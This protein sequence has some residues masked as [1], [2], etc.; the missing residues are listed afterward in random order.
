M[1][2]FY[3]LAAFFFIMT[4]VFFTALLVVFQKDARIFLSSIN[5]IN[6]QSDLYI[7][8]PQITDGTSTQ[9]INTDLFNNPKYKKLVKS[10]VDMTGISLPGPA[11]TTPTTTTTVAAS[12]TPSFKVGNSDPFK[13]F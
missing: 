9:A 11:S 5:N 12:T 3:R 6:T 8:R 13:S 10:E 2:K 7:V 4:A 1:K